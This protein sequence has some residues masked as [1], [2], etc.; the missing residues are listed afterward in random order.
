[1]VSATAFLGVNEEVWKE[2]N[3]P[4]SLAYVKCGFQGRLKDEV[5]PEWNEEETEDE[6]RDGDDEDGKGEEVDVNSQ[7]SY[8]SET[9]RASPDIQAQPRAT[10]PVRSY[11]LRLG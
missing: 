1:M 2:R 9:K 5:P 10:R 11:N 6:S 3:G 7:S 4:T 8:G